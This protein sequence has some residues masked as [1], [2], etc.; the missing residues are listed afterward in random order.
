M[1]QGRR[2]VIYCIM[3]WTYFFPI[4]SRVRMTFIHKILCSLGVGK[5]SL[6]RKITAQDV[7]DFAEFRLAGAGSPYS[8]GAGGGDSACNLFVC[9]T[10]VA[11]FETLS[12]ERS[13]LKVE[14]FATTGGMRGKGLGESCLR[15]FTRQLKKQNASINSIQFD[16]ARMAGNP[17]SRDVRMLADARENLLRRIGASNISRYVPN[18]S[19]IVVR[20]TWNKEC[21]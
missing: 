7:N 20:G 4:W 5:S 2:P 3:C 6:P 13:T 21:W 19:R 8:F 11:S 17:S 9:S 14:H 18:N 15:A 1:M 16:L 10:H 12:Y